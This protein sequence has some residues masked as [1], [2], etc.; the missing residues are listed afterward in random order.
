MTM[1]SKRWVAIGGTAAVIAGAGVF[2]ARATLFSPQDKADRLLADMKTTPEEQR[3]E[4][5]R[6]IREQ[7][8]DMS[9]E[10]QRKLR[11]G[12][13][14]MFE[15]QMDERVNEYE[16]APEDQKLAVLDKHID[17]MVERRAEWEKRR[18]EREAERAQGGDSQPTGGSQPGSG[19]AARGGPQGR[20]PGGPRQPPT[21]EERKR[22]MEGS[23]PDSQV[24][25]MRYF[26]AVRERAQERGIDMGRGPGG[27]GPG[28]RNSA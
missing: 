1:A 3:F 4:G 17:E 8:G 9:D 22:R 5:M 27:R 12:M 19:D 13:R 10:E 14:A 21:I 24:R 6:R 23:N 16:N 7:V 26:R 11:D 2:I 20:G 28:G 18:A 25:R 15:E